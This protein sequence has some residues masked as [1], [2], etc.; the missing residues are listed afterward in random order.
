MTKWLERREKVLHHANFILWR[1]QQAQHVSPPRIQWEP[2]DMACS[3][4]LKMTRHPSAKVSIS[5]IISDSQYGASQ[6]VSAF[7]HFVTQCNYPQFSRH[8]IIQ[9]AEGFQL[10]FNSLPVYHIIKF[11]NEAVY[12]DVTLDSIHVQPPRFNNEQIIAPARFDT[13]LIQLR[14]PTSD[15]TEPHPSVH[16][17]FYICYKTF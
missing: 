16:G 2:P 6:F 9:H 15:V 13:A 4:H 8:Q 17:M 3:L 11:W 10:P 5:N 14:N 7:G 12:G 1:Q